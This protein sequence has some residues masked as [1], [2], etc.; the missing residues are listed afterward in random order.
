[1]R[2]E[3]L[4]TI[5]ADVLAIEQ[6]GIDDSFFELGGDSL[7]AT[8]LIARVRTALN[9]EP[10]LR[11]VFNSPTVATMSHELDLID[12]QEGEGLFDIVLP[13]NSKECDSPVWWIHPGGGLS[14]CYMIYSQHMDVGSYAIQARGLNGRERI[15]S[16][17]EDLIEDYIEKILETQPAGPFNIAGW[18]L[19][20]TLAH[21]ISCN[22]QLRGHTVKTLSIIDSLP[23][24]FLKHD[25]ESE[26]IEHFTKYI[27]TNRS[28]TESQLG[29]YMMNISL[30][31]MRMFAEYS[32]PTYGGDVTFFSADS[33]RDLDISNIWKPYV[34]GNIDRNSIKCTHDEVVLPHISQEVARIIKLSLG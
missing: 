28:P 17:I 9:V 10:T 14:W 11:M 27:D 34:T 16:T 22:L 5:F 8:R 18:S 19:G 24:E 25:A 20:G 6:V 1:P 15:P 13:L 21:G 4:C 23:G 3:L 30:S 33:E 12:D 26:I 2:E 7:L 32:T 29:H 31:H